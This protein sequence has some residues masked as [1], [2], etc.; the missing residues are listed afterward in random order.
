MVN[1]FFI[2]I[3]IIHRCSWVFLMLQILKIGIYGWR[4]IL[5]HV[6]FHPNMHS[7]FLAPARIIEHCSTPI[8]S[9]SLKRKKVQAFWLLPKFFLILGLLKSRIS[10]K[11]NQ[12]LLNKLDFKLF[13]YKA[14]VQPVSKI[15][16]IA[17]RNSC[18]M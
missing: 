11:V 9:R 1:L 5:P 13:H 7:P 3:Q 18:W 17:T 10:E 6:Q 12:S 14:R 16:T 15:S 4:N 8:Y 2:K